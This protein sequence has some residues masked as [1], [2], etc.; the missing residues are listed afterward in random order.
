M[1]EAQAILKAAGYT[2][3]PEKKGDLDPGGERVLGQVCQRA[4]TTTIS[5]SLPTGRPVSGPFTTCAI[6]DQPGLTR[7]YDLIACGLEIT[8]GAQRE[9][10]LTRCWCSQAQEKGLGLE[11]IRFYL[12]FFRYGCP[13]HGGFGFGLSR[14]LMV[15]LGLANVR[16]AVFLFRGPHRLSLKP[17]EVCSFFRRLYRMNK[18]RR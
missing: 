12:D 4:N 9:H 18:D 11:P 14:F 3:P 17:L 7:S 10:R 1:A 15:L 5:C 8:T 2:L 13:P 16:E 6:L